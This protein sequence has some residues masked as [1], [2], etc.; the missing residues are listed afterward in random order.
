M[1]TTLP[2]LLDINVRSTLGTYTT[3]RVHG[4]QA[5][6]TAGPEQAARRL[7]EKLYGPSLVAVIQAPYIQQN[8]ESFWS[9]HAEPVFAWAWPSGLIEFGRVVPDGALKFATGIDTALRERVGVLARHGRGKSDG[10]LLVPG[11]PEA[12]N[13]DDQ[14][15]ALIAWVDWCARGNGQEPANGVVFERGL[16]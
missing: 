14:L 3:D 12:E 13:E 16:N 2:L 7:G 11:V 8:G 1:T 10:K 9:L 6:C 15:D 4:K 5:S